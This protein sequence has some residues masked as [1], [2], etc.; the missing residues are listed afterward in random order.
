MDDSSLVR[1]NLDLGSLGSYLMDSNSLIT[2][3]IIHINNL[4]PIIDL[5]LVHPDLVDW[6]QRNQE[7]ELLT[8]QNDYEIACYLNVIKPVVSSTSE[9]TTSMTEPDI[10]YLSR[11][12]KRKE[13]KK[14]KSSDGE[15]HYLAVSKP[16]K[17]K[18]KG[19]I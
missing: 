15:N 13:K 3:D 6:S 18:N 9:P 19:C 4:I 5:P 14:K 8:F 11:K 7:P 17:V 2:R 12:I 16:K 1:T 10:K